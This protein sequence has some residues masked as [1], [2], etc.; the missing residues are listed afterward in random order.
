[1]QYFSRHRHL[2]TNLALGTFIGWQLPVINPNSTGV[3]AQVAATCQGQK[4]NQA[5]QEKT[6]FLAFGGGPAPSANEI[7]IE[8]N[9]LYFQRTLSAMGYNPSQASTFFA[10]GNDGQA[11]VRYLD[12]SGQQQ[13][14]VPQIPNLNGASTM[15]NLERSIQDLSKNPK[16]IFLYFTGH[17]IPN[18]EDIDNN[19]FLLWNKEL[20]TV[21]QFA[22]MLDS[23]PDQTPVVTMMSQC[24]AGSFANLIYQGGDPKR[25]VALQTRCGFFATVKTRPSVGCTPAVNEA[26]YRD[27]SSSFFAGLSGRSRTGQPVSSADYNKDGRVS[28][29]EAHA[30]AKVDEKTTD[31]PISTSEAWLQNQADKITQQ[32]ILSRPIAE[33]LQRSRP[34]QSYAVNSIAKMFDF[35]LQKSLLANLQ[36]LD[37]SKIETEEQ[38]AYIIRLGMELTNIGMEKQIRSSQNSQAI[39]TLDK[40]IKCESSSWKQ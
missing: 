33:L 34:E 31:W 30:F 17:G 39:A 1:M 8:K 20:L 7:A 3:N 4:Q 10:N 14:K 15:A 6:N 36:G 27:Y 11:T 5:Q 19:A 24:F 23:L 25:P 26:D 32:A 12:S 2:I 21:Q 28:Y 9:I 35:N 37:R 22:T 13:F 40:L 18:P 38:K 29:A 16:S